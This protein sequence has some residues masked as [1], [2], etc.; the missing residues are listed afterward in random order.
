MKISNVTKPTLAAVTLAVVLAGSVVCVGAAGQTPDGPAAKAPAT[1]PVRPRWFRDLFPVC[2]CGKWGFIDANGHLAIQPAFQKAHYFSGGLAA[3]QIDGKYGY[4]DRTGKVVIPPQFR[5]GF[6]FREGLAWVREEAGGGGFIDRTGKIVLRAPQG[7][8][9]YE[10]R[11]GLAL[12]S[13]IP[14]RWPTEV[15]DNR[16]IG[17]IDKTGRYAIAPNLDCATSFSEGLAGVRVNGKWGFIDKAGKTVIDP[18][19]DEVWHFS[20]GLTCVT[21]SGKS[22][23]LDRKGKAA[24]DKNFEDAHGFHEGLAGVKI[25]GMWGFIDKTGRVVIPPGF[26]SVSSFFSGRAAVKFYSKKYSYIDRTGKIVTNQKYDTANFFLGEL[27]S[28][29]TEKAA[30]DGSNY[31]YINRSGRVVWKPKAADQ[32]TE[33]AAGNRARMCDAD[34]TAR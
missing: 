34:G 4:I 18:Q 8:S 33:S 9:C 10:F 28:V 26:D 17:F 24:F 23:F 31:M 21:L 5:Y 2:D 6:G 20:E 15:P 14:R 12:A 7:F 11:D 25:D 29:C 13:P 3:V 19:F 30:S 16:K 32:P 22:F 1:Q 27:A